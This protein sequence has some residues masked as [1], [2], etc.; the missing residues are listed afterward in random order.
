MGLKASL[1]PRVPMKCEKGLNNEHYTAVAVTV[2]Q[3]GG[4]STSGVFY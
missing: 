2:T 3:L 1:M 4:M